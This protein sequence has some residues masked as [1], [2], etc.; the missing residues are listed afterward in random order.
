MPGQQPFDSG[1]FRKALGAFA[2]GVTVVT[3]RD[4]SN[5]DV[6]LTAN[7]FNSVS[8]DPPMVLW[9]LGKKSR[10]LP[11]FR[12]EKYFA[13]HILSQDQEELSGRF[14]RSGEDKF[15]GIALERGP[16]DIPLLSDFAARFI[17]RT[18]YQYEGGDH[19]I[20]VGEVE[21]FVHTDLPPLLFHGGRYGQIL[22]KFDPADHS[23]QQPLAESATE[24][25][26]SYLLRLCFHQI[27]R[28]LKEELSKRRIASS[29]Y[30]FLALLARR[31]K[32]SLSQLMDLLALGDMTLT[33]RDIDD[34]ENRKWVRLR[35]DQVQ[36]TSKGLQLHLEL[37]S[38]FKA[39]E[40]DVLNT[41]DY[42][43]RQTLRILLSQLIETSKPPMS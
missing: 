15:A 23:G 42:N 13:V 31:E 35:D 30:F 14:A 26:L 1:E 5:L 17:C 4:Q 24:H 33:R 27:S 40:S 16:D 20:F 10:S 34:L 18:A 36:L 32:S 39:G 3:T 12:K 7:S 29:Q 22:K 38:I 9:S 21:D 25:S 28:P 43:T 2:T 41:L 6:G 19:I 37:T 8:L 11:T